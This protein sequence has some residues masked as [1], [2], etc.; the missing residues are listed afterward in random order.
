MNDSKI[1]HA[2]IIIELEKEMKLI[3]SAM[4]YHRLRAGQPLGDNGKPPEQPTRMEATDLRSDTFF[5]MS[6][7]DAI[8]QFLATTKQPQLAKA[9]VEGLKQGGILTEAKNF[10]SNVYTSLIRLEESGEVVRLGK[11]WG[12]AEWYPNRVKSV[13]KAK[14]EQKHSRTAEAA[15]T[16]KANGNLSYREFVGVKRKEGKTMKEAAV[17]WQNYKQRISLSSPSPAVSVL[18]NEPALP[19]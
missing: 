15:R 10:Y 5:R 1:D 12:L 11:K 6:V 19:E 7:P 18:P 16:I 8:K 3:E 17:E 4:A 13:R 9:I 14:T 2:A